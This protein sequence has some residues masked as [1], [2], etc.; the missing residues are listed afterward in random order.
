MLTAKSEAETAI[1]F[2]LK[3]IPSVQK[4]L[5]HM[6][7]YRGLSEAAA[8]VNFFLR[9]ESVCPPAVCPR[10]VQACESAVHLARSQHV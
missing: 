3:Q 5:S 2:Q 1:A 8:C 9:R 7:L 6:L 4:H 10:G